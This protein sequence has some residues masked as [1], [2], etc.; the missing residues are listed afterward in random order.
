MAATTMSS[1]AALRGA[2]Q[3]KGA[4]SSDFKGAKLAAGP[5]LKQKAVA[6]AQT[7]AV[8]APQTYKYH[9]DVKKGPGTM[10]QRYDS[11]PRGPPVNDDSHYTGFRKSSHTPIY[12]GLYIPG[13]YGSFARYRTHTIMFAL[14]DKNLP[15]ESFGAF[16]YFTE[17]PL[18]VLNGAVHEGKNAISNAFNSIFN[19]S[20]QVYWEILHQAEDEEKVT[21]QCHAKFQRKMDGSVVSSPA[22]FKFY[23]DGDVVSK[24]VL[25]VDLAGLFGLEPGFGHIVEDDTHYLQRAKERLVNMLF[26]CV[27]QNTDEN[28][29]AFAD[30]NLTSDCVYRVAGDDV[31]YGPNDTAGFLRDMFALANPLWFDVRGEWVIGNTVISEYNAVYQF[32]ADNQIHPTPCTDVYRFR[33]DKCVEWRPYCDR[34]W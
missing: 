19:V 26:A 15:A 31:I 30:V 33:A 20:S 32:K 22:T 12:R 34:R 1:V 23:Y 29:K 11:H 6:R 27:Y 24:L 5:A 17:N 18:L 14:E 2:Q 10:V 3:Q 28:W 7:Q 4:L 16:A 8:Q 21:V 9:W 25:D 13:D